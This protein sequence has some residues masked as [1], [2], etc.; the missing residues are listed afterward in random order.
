MGLVGDEGGGGW[1]HARCLLF[2]GWVSRMEW[3]PWPHLFLMALC[4]STGQAGC[5]WSAWL[6]RTPG[7]QG[8]L[9]PYIKIAFKKSIAL[10]LFLI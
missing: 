9:M 8:D 10:H 4:L 3:D 2:G 6:P 5:S 1:G 7:P